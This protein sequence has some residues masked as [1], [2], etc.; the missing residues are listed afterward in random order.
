[1]K[2]ETGQTYLLI[3]RLLFFGVTPDLSDQ[4]GINIGFISTHISNSR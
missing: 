2:D 4:A 1:M 3:K